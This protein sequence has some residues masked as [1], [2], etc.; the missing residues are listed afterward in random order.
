MKTIEGSHFPETDADGKTQGITEMTTLE[1]FF[2]VQFLDFLTT[3]VGLHLGG[4]EISP[5]IRMPLHVGPVAG[6]TA[7]KALGCGIA[8]FCIYTQRQRVLS[9]ANYFF[10]GLVVWNLVQIL[11]AVSWGYPKFRRQ[12]CSW[13]QGVIEAGLQGSD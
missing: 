3:L 10:A 4:S 13:A 8:G 9:W 7:V 12:H 1:M 11:K 5:F 2:F 6:L